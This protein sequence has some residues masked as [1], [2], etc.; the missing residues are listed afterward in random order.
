MGPALLA[1]WHISA[2]SGVAFLVSF[3]TVLVGTTALIILLFGTTKFLSASMRHGLILLS[4]VLLAAL[5]VYRLVLS[6]AGS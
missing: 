1:A 2:A 3:Y 4:A 6:V 5:G